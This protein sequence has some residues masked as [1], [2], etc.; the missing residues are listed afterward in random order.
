MTA[1]E[2]LIE[3]G[4]KEIQEKTLL[5]LL[6]SRF[7]ALPDAAAARICAADTSRLGDWFDRA[8]TAASLD[9]VLDGA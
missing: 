8:L 1:G 2:V 9:E 7:G 3:R 4:R 5:K 6:R